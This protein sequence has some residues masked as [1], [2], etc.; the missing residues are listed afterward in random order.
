[1]GQQHQGEAEVVKKQP[2]PRPATCMRRLA[3]ALQPLL[4]AIPDPPSTPH[5]SLPVAL[6]TTPLTELCTSEGPQLLHQV[7]SAASHHQQRM[8]HQY[9]LFLCL[10]SAASSKQ[11]QIFNT[12]VALI[13][14]N[15][16]D[17]TWDMR[18]AQQLPARPA[19]HQLSEAGANAEHKAGA[20]LHQ[21]PKQPSNQRH[22]V[23]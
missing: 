19:L 16:A 3:Q 17:D 6:M 14:F 9:A 2:I 13:G 21:E 22:L 8:A 5:S 18:P 23:A 15:R 7:S 11:L 12:S 10:W 1:M 20:R 4:W